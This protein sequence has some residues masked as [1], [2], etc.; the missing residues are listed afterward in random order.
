MPDPEPE[1]VP[2]S[3]AARPSPHWVTLGKESPPLS[4]SLSLATEEGLA[5]PR[6]PLA[7]RLET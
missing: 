6:G 5:A 2:S 1:A 3:Q 4:G 7:L